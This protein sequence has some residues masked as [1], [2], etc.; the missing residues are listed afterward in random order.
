MKSTE[1]L[2]LGVGKEDVMLDNAASTPP[3]V[4][5]Y[6]RVNDALK[7]YGSIHRGFGPRSVY[8]TKMY[9][10]AREYMLLKM[11][12]TDKETL[13]FTSNTTDGINRVAMMLLDEKEK[14]GRDTVIVSEMEHSANLLPFVY[15]FNILQV[16]MDD[17][18]DIDI[19]HLESL[20][21]KYKD[22][23]V[24][25]SLT[26]ASNVTGKVIPI[27]QINELIKSIDENIWFLIDASQYAPHHKIDLQEADFYMFS[28]HKMYAPYGGGV[29]AGKKKLMYNMKNAFKGGGDIIFIKSDNTPIFKEPPFGHEMGTPNYVGAISMAESYRILHEEIGMEAVEKYEKSVFEQLKRVLLDSDIVVPYVLNYP[30]AIIDFKVDNETVKKVFNEHNVN[31][32]M[33]HFC[34]FRF[35]E[36]IKNINEKKNVPEDYNVIRLSVGLPTTL[37]QVEKFA[38]VLKILKEKV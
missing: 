36:R 10:S 25:V 30:M 4:K 20:L 15:R 31:A 9:E 28:G 38:D 27:G 21:K 16:K 13:F 3:F 22:K 5:V 35:I 37:A 23:I 2:F 7:R 11:N 29:V 19:N 34:V 24:A 1:N 32:R 17:N 26:G 8:S 12:G 33:G 6:E 14:T 18:F